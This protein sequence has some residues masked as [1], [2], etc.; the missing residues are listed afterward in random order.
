LGHAWIKKEHPLRPAR[1]EFSS[2]FPEG[3]RGEQKPLNGG[4]GRASAES[5]A[6][7]E[8][9]GPRLAI[10]IRQQRCLMTPLQDFKA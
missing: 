8:K 5:I 2:F 1:L 7:I 10:L 9:R 4:N 6:K 3:R